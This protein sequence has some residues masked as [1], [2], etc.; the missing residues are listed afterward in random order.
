MWCLWLK[1]RT[2]AVYL[3]TYK[4]L[5]F[6]SSNW[7]VKIMCLCAK[8]TCVQTV[9]TED[10]LCLCSQGLNEKRPHIESFQPSSNGLF[11]G[12]D[13]LMDKSRWW[14]AAW[15]CRAESW[16]TEGMRSV[17]TLHREIS[18]E[19]RL[20]SRRVSSTATHDSGNYF[21]MLVNEHWLFPPE[22]FPCSVLIHSDNILFDFISD[23]EWR[24]ASF[25]GSSS[26]M[27]VSHGLIA[28][29]N[30]F[31]WKLQFS[32]VKRVLPAATSRCQA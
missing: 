21:L 26:N 17:V 4:L 3:D 10:V 15:D 13:W 31:G 8:K 19:L 2:H 9:L 1:I 30:L 24:G 12:P 28:K 29:K 14:R 25:F 22:A 5:L 18:P 6:F 32:A 27:N 20:E 23:R 16:V 11:I 7:S